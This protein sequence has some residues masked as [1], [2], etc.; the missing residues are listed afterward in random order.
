MMDEHLSYQD[1]LHRVR[2]LERNEKLLKEKN[3]LLELA[4]DAVEDGVWEMD[5]RTGKTYYSPRWFTMLGYEPGELPATYETWR[6]LLHPADRGPLEEA[7]QKFLEDPQDLYSAEF[8]MRTRQGDWR[9][10]HSR[11]K[12]MGRDED[13]RISRM[14]GTHVDITERRQLEDSL[15]LTQFIY[16]KA[17]VGI[18]RVGADARILGVNDQAAKSL[19]Y[20]K[21]ELTSMSIFD[22]DPL[23]TTDNWKDIWERFL[24]GE[25]DSFETI[26]RHKDGTE[27]PVY[28]TSNL[29]VYDGQQ[30][31]IAF[32]QDITH[33]KR[34]EQALYQAQKME[35]IGNLAGGIAHDFNNVLSAIYGYSQLAQLK[36]NNKEKVLE[37]IRNICLASDRAKELVQQILAFSR[38]GVSE[39]APIDL[40]DN[41]KD[42]L[43]LLKASIPST[44]EMQENI[45]VERGV[46][47]ANRIQIQQVV[48]NLCAN[49]A[50]ALQSDGGKI[51]VEL[52][53][54]E[55]CQGD[56]SD[57]PDIIPGRYL[58]LI[59]ADNGHGIPA[60]IQNR[61]FEPYFT[62]KKTGEGTG[63]GLATVHG[64]IKDHGG[65]IKVY[66]KPGTGTTFQVLFPVT[67]HNSLPDHE[68]FEA[69]PRGT[70][71]ILFVDDEGS[72]LEIGRTLLSNL[73]YRVEA[74]TS[75]LDCLACFR[76]R[77]DE[78][79]L[80][81][82][83]FAMPG[84]D[85]KIFV[86]EI[87][88]IHP[89]IP[90]IVCTGFSANILSEEMTDLGIH[91]ILMKPVST[92]E[93]AMTV[94][95]AI[96]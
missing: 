82:T 3:E 4:I 92:S 36:V 34:I 24:D 62:T 33:L 20:S 32:V 90:I 71:R 80:V 64:I 76:A 10:V 70:E 67:G 18:F 31:S 16:E 86:A 54:F 65:Y 78:F 2:D 11:G 50:H 45:A 14:I 96:G 17:S 58:K 94:R 83:D 55:V 93:L 60:D 6:D 40:G 9:W 15:R 51:V 38:Q 37:Y 43:K 77:P 53:P 44:I 22:I 1:L 23:A 42:A 19:G 47:H 13:G 25:G 91:S 88:K 46:V 12:I 27:L 35:A 56:F 63:M 61:I 81:L 7:V 79:D 85:G 41:I 48:M 59:V 95:R 49:S 39:K 72:I 21:E 66:S 73:G 26:H 28:I 68:R 8:R 87:R 84:M 52:L 29:L 30:F 74:S 89:T 69:L 5:P 75:P 57:D